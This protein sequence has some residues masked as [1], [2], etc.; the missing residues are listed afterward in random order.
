MDQACCDGVWLGAGTECDFTPSIGGRDMICDS[1]DNCPF[2]AKIQ[3]LNGDVDG[4]GDG[5]SDGCGNCPT[6]ANT[7]HADCDVD[8]HDVFLVSVYAQ[9]SSTNDD[10]G[11][12]LEF[13]P[14]RNTR[15]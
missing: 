7:D 9:T 10:A 11:D 3:Q 2:E 5:L 6:L 4:D 15:V 13:V 14:V 12:F 1:C 8:E